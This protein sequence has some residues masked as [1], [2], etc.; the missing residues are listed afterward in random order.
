LKKAH[1]LKLA[2]LNPK[3]IE[4]TS[5]K[6]AISVFCESTRDALYH[7]ATHE[8]KS[9]WKSGSANFISFIIKLWNVMNVKSGTKGKHKRNVTMDPVRSPE[10]DF[11]AQKLQISLFCGKAPNYLD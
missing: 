9:K 4:K 5:I 1:T 11:S 3:S 6:L 2:A 8:G 10:V 7:Y